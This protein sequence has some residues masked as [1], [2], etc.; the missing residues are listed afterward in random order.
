MAMV[1]SFLEMREPRPA[2]DVPGI[3][4]TSFLSGQRQLAGHLERVSTSRQ[5]L[6]D[7]ARSA[8]MAALIE[9]AGRR[10]TNPV[11][12]LASARL[13]AIAIS[14]VLHAVA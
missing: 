12:D 6:L 5:R 2:A 4:V 8:D 7:L 1:R 3:L 11:A 10:G 14:G 9:L 13:R